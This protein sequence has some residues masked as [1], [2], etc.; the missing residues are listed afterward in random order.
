MF[1][2]SSFLVKGSTSALERCEC[3]KRSP[4]MAQRPHLILRELATKVPAHSP[5]W[6]PWRRQRTL[7]HDVGA[8]HTLEP[9]Y[10]DRGAL[11]PT[12]KL[13][14]RS[15][16]TQPSRVPKN[17]RVKGFTPFTQPNPHRELKP[18]HQMQWQ[19][20]KKCS[21]PSLPNSNKATKAYGGIREEEHKKNTKFSKT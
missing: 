20:H 19:A 3:H 8:L 5:L 9:P 12:L 15:L 10:D 2:R 18:M 16:P 17:P 11:Q 14:G 7:V 21:S 4:Q 13:R 1:S 6:C